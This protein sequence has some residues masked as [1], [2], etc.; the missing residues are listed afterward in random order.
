VVRDKSRVPACRQAGYRYTT[1]RKLFKI[2]SSGRGEIRTHGELPHDGFQ[3][4]CL[5]PLG[6][7]SNAEREGFEPSIRI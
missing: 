4:R 6:H 5:K 3:D 7:S 2:N 1:A